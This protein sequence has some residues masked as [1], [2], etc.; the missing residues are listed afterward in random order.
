VDLGAD[1]RILDKLAMNG[2]KLAGG[3]TGVVKVIDMQGLDS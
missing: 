3:R 2:A 1:S